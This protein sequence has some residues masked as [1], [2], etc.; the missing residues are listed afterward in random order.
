MLA[1][2]LVAYPPHDWSATA[3][4]ISPLMRTNQWS[5]S[6][7]F[8]KLIEATQHPT[9]IAPVID[10]ANYVTRQA[11]VTAHPASDKKAE[12]ISLLGGVVSRLGL[13]EE[14]PQRFGETVAE[15]Q[16]VLGE[17][18]AL[19]VAL[20]DALGWFGDQQA[21]GKLNQA[22]KLTH[23]RVQ[24]EAAAALAKLGDEEGTNALVAL[25]SEPS[26]RLRVLNYAEELM[27]ADRI[28]PKWTSSEAQAE[29][30]L[31]IWLSQPQQ[32]GLPPTELQL[33]DQRTLY[34]PGYEEP[35]EC[36]LFRYA[37][38]MGDVELS[39]IGIAGPMVH[40]FASDLANLPEDDIYAAFAGWCA[41][42]EDIYEVDTHHFNAAQAQEA[43]R[44]SDHMEED[45]LSE[46]RPMYLGFFVGERALVAMAQRGD[47][48]GIAVSDGLELLWLQTEGRIRP[49]GD[50]EV[51]SIFKGRKIIRTFNPGA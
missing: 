49:L 47:H 12:W 15:V 10:L 34:W 25:A 5:V 37:Y 11:M 9:T 1:D 30:E 39:N 50:L 21:I 43:K 51:Y 18:V 4:A 19:C 36:F 32:F 16:H 20:S 6:D 28:D 35:R 7:V 46:I 33:L 44:L 38:K 48:D 22:M 42:H 40:S 24:T 17:S 31:A 29:S 14:E 23:R 26:A 3:I 13:L 8:P 41:E 2:I 45:G 27:I